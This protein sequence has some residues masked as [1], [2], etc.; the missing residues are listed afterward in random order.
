MNTL[1]NGAIAAALAFATTGLA[2][3]NETPKLADPGTMTDD[4]K[5][6]VRM[7]HDFRAC[8][9]KVTDENRKIREA[10][11]EKT[12]IAARVRNDAA[13]EK[14]R[15]ALLAAGISEKNMDAILGSMLAQDQG[16]LAEALA[17][18][19]Y[20]DPQEICLKEV[21]LDDPEAANAVNEKLR[22]I[23]KKYGNDV[24]TPKQ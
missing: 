7:L 17:E 14:T 8:G 12:A 21:K 13:Q 11:E 2:F 3:A 9:M 10:A 6:T 4:E 16:L 22:A 1:K 5:T 19:S 20:K 15:K 23:A 24:L 18:S